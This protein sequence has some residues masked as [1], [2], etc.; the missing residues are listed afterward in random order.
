M[1]EL[2]NDI[3]K[4]PVEDN[5]SFRLKEKEPFVILR[6]NINKL[7]EKKENYFNKMLE[8]N[9]NLENV[10]YEL[11]ASLNQLLA[12]ENE[13]RSQYD[14]LLLSKEALKISEKEIKQL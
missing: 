12:I 4:I 2:E 8:S 10:N 9:K 6:A 1:I 5:F 11:E 3:D 7:L 13:L 14:E